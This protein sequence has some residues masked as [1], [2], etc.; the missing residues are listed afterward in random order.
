MLRRQQMHERKVFPRRETIPYI[1]IFRVDSSKGKYFAGYFFLP[2][3]SEIQWTELDSNFCAITLRGQLPSLELD[4]SLVG[5]SI[6]MPRP[7][8]TRY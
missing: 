6:R 7:S 8:E 2:I 5:A 1:R 3:L 4:C